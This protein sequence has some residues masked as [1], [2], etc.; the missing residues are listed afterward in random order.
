MNPRPANG[1]G[2]FYLRTNPVLNMDPFAEVSLSAINLQFFN[3]RKC[4]DL[5][6]IYLCGR[7]IS[8]GNPG[9]LKHP[10]IAGKWKL[11][12]GRGLTLNVNSNT[13]QNTLFPIS[14]QTHKFI[15]NVSRREFQHHD[16]GRPS[17]SRRLGSVWLKG[18]LVVPTG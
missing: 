2:V 5:I 14:T 9:L 17:R 11:K 3:H 13:G 6:F 8:I 18:F 7:M 10:S 15:H 4:L 16:L 1:K 12:S